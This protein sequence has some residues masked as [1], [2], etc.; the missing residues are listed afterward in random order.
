MGYYTL[1]AVFKVDNT[2]GFRDGDSQKV[3]LVHKDGEIVTVSKFLFDTCA[4]P[5]EGPNGELGR[6][7]EPA[8]SATEPEGE[9]LDNGFGEVASAPIENTEEDTLALGES[10]TSGDGYSQETL[11]TEGN[12]PAAPAT[13]LNGTGATSEETTS[14]ADTVTEEE[15]SIPQE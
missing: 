6:P 11:G 4:I 2:N 5:V 13:E 15:N 7:L 10:L 3:E 1:N 14:P 12:E 8:S 9:A